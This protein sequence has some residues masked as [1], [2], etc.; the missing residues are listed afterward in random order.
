MRTVLVL[1]ACASGLTACGKVGDLER[2]GPMFGKAAADGPAEPATDPAAP[3]TTVD[4]RDRSTDIP[5]ISRPPPGG[6]S[7]PFAR[8]PL[9]GAAPDPATA[10][11]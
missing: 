8:P 6:P 10:P 11:R 3:V 9:P 2:P 1:L 5:P 7:D 4:P